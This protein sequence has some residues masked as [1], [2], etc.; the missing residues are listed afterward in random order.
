[1]AL[2]RKTRTQRAAS[3]TDQGALLLWQA[4][5]LQ[6]A[7]NASDL[8]HFS[9]SDFSPKTLRQ[10]G[11]MSSKA[12][13]PLRAIQDLTDKGIAV[14]IVPPLPGTFLDGA[15]MASSAGWPVI[16]LTLRH[17]RVDSFWFTLMHE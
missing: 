2:L 7:E 15:A 3:K 11:R 1:P 6:K 10:I 12:N 8:G 4:A 13:G 14:V 5:V 17:D 9:L 16:G